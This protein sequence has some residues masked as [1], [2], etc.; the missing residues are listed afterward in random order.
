MSFYTFSDTTVATASAQAT[1]QYLQ[2]KEKIRFSEKERRRS[3]RRTRNS[4]QLG[5]ISYLVSPHTLKTP[6]HCLQYARPT[7]KFYRRKKM[8]LFLLAIGSI[9]RPAD[10]AWTR[11]WR[12][13]SQKCDHKWWNARAPVKMSNIVLRWHHFFLLGVGVTASSM[14]IGFVRCPPV[15][16]K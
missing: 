11:T 3:I 10:I 14:Y 16:W 1:G 9:L 6:L 15:E 12:S 7:S 4:C 5:R 13:S 2:T 8:F